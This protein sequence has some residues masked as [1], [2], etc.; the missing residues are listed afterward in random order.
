MSEEEPR[1]GNFDH[2]AAGRREAARER[3][4][5]LAATQRSAY[6]QALTDDE[7][8]RRLGPDARVV[9]SVGRTPVAGWEQLAADAQLAHVGSD[10]PRPSRLDPDT[11]QAEDRRLGK[12]VSVGK[13]G[14]SR[15]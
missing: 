11:V 15:Y 1:L 5:W 6:A 8:R 10:S 14:P 13:F 3:D 12:S 9:S 7:V 2:D 4:E